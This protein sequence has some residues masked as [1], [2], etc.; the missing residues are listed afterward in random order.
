M[1][2]HP[3]GSV[4]CPS[5]AKRSEPPRRE[6]SKNRFQF[7]LILFKVQDAKTGHSVQYQRFFLALIQVLHGIA[8]KRQPASMIRQNPALSLDLPLRM[9]FR[10]QVSFRVRHQSEYAA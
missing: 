5:C 2:N 3:W 7:D 8:E 1:R 9:I 10:I 6:S 4:S